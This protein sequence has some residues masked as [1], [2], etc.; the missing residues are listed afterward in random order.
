MKFNSMI[1]QGK[2]FLRGAVKGMAAVAETGVLEGVPIVS[3]ILSGAQLIN[4]TLEGKEEAD[5]SLAEVKA[6]V[7]LVSPIVVKIAGAT[8]K[9]GDAGLTN[10]LKAVSDVLEELWEHVD[11]YVKKGDFIKYATA[12]SN[13][14]TFTEDL[15]TLRKA[16]DI[17]SF[18][19]TGETFVA[20][21]RTEGKVDDIA[22]GVHTT[23]QA[24]YGIAASQQIIG[25]QINALGA[26]KTVQ[27]RRVSRNLAMEIDDRN[28]VLEDTPFANGSFGD[29]YL[30]V[31]ERQTVVAKVISLK[32]VA[33]NALEAT[34]KEYMK[35]V[36]LMGE[37]RSQNIVRIIGAITRPTE[38]VI[39]MEFCE[40]GDLRGLLDRALVGE[41]EFDHINQSNM[42][43]QVSYG[44]RF[45]HE[46]SIIHGDFKSLNIL[47]D[48]L[49]I[50]KVADFG[51]SRSNSMSSSMSAGSGIGTHG[52]AAPEVIEGG[53]RAL[54]LKADVYAFGIVMWE[55]ITKKRPWDGKTDG[56][57]IKAI[58]KEQR[59]EVDESMDKDLRPLMELCWSEDPKVRPHFDVI[60]KKLEAITPPKVQGMLSSGTSFD[61]ASLPDRVRSEVSNAKAFDTPGPSSSPS[62]PTKSP[63]G[64]RKQ[65]TAAHQL[66]LEIW[67]S[68]MAE[69]GGSDEDASERPWDD[70]LV[71]AIE[72]ELLGGED[73]TQSQNAALRGALTKGS[74][75]IK[76]N[77]WKKFV[78]KWQKNKEYA[79]DFVR[80][81]STLEVSTEV[82]AKED[83]R[84]SRTPNGK[85][86][87]KT[88]KTGSE[89][90]SRQKTLN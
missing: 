4:D 81:L 15:D 11:T 31:Y 61:G 36:A 43:L 45:L 6:T 77:L 19:L 21:L 73:M 66:A 46:K 38:L 74:N 37:L 53:L 35:E 28:V 8:D 33:P 68:I 9:V 85:S 10:N 63:A 44:M 47:I 72:S 13:T 17:L 29:V 60:V 54:S 32:N 1:S 80:Y 89:K 26:K 64:G 34:K 82:A 65:R 75:I 90:P 84:A 49:G 14:S 71:T 51:K 55:C 12:G 16:L 7:E 87:L 86:R 30:A 56:Q 41:A 5:D 88:W 62:S 24:V 70:D 40:G 79:E 23:Q 58:M 59:P 76:L 83:A 42:L 48:R 20:V 2:A 27:E 67:A 22:L 25:D 78:T 52:W 50:G 69:A 39:L 3:N 57:I 18:T